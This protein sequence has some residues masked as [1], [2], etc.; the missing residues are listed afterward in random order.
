[1]MLAATESLIFASWSI[2]GVRVHCAVPVLNQV[3]EAAMQGFRLFPHGGLEVGGVLFGLRNAQTVQILAATPLKIEYANGP[4]YVLSEN[5]EA[6]LSTLL[7]NPPNEIRKR[8]WEVVGWYQSHT[9]RS[10][11]LSPRDVALY[12]R[13]FGAPGSVCLIL[14][15]DRVRGVD[16]VLQVRDHDLSLRTADF[17]GEVSMLEAQ[18]AP[19]E[20]AAA[21]SALPEPAPESTAP[22]NPQPPAAEP[23]ADPAPQSPV[24][25]HPVYE[26][27][28]GPAYYQYRTT[29]RRRRKRYWIP[30]AA[31][32]LCAAALIWLFVSRKPGTAASR[33]APQ[34]L[35]TS[36][37]APPA[38]SVPKPA[39]EAKPPITVIENIGPGNKASQPAKKAK[40]PHHRRSRRRWD[41]E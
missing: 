17:S 22:A 36:T 28:P 3:R 41:D 30:A 21:N 34:P 9:R 37:A 35:T 39:E 7:G 11:E 14:K 1:M 32:A 24:E 29:R 2:P 15:P 10:I 4:S 13:F 5:D 19:A 38:A 33:P 8:G 6:A 40:R 27:L 20:P 16:T 31:L 12:E 23:V 25:P 18:P 26:P